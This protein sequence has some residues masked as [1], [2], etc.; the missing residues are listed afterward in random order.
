MRSKM[1]EIKAKFP[2]GKTQWSKWTDAQKTAFNEL[3]AAG[4][5]LMEAVDAVNAAKAVEAAPVEVVETVDTPPPQK[6]PRTRGRPR[7]GA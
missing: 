5:S 4:A 6:K 3:S 2:I 1:A 7:K